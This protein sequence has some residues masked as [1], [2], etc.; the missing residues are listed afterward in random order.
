MNVR[1]L[2]LVFTA[3][4]VSELCWSGLTPLVPD[5]IEL[6]DLT[7]F[8]GGLIFAVAGVG[9]LV[10]SL[11]A[12]YITQRISP[13]ILTLWALAVVILTCYA[14][15]F[16]PGYWSLV[17]TRA[18]F[19]VA[20]GTLWVSIVA[21]LDQAAG[22]QSPRVL[23][24]TTTTVAVAATLSPAYAGW[25]AQQFSLGA[26]FVGL[27]VVMSFV[28]LM[29]LFERSGT[30]LRKDPAPPARALVRSMGSDPGLATMLLLT[31]AAAMMWMTSD[32][33][34]PLRLDDAGY[35]A[36]GIGLAFS[37]AACVFAIAS[38]VAARQANHWTRPRFAAFWTL[39]TAAAT[40]IPTVFAGVPA[41]LAFL[42]AASIATG[43]TI[44]LTFPFGLL[45]VNRGVVS[46]AVMSAMANIIWAVSGIAGPT[47]GGAFAEWAGDQVAFGVLAMV[48]VVVAALVIW[49]NRREPESQPDLIGEADIS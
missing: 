15:P 48:S 29:L 17:L 45:A 24:L 19:G 1:V 5:Y 22:D 21:W 33:L 11:P 32:L 10:A 31:I 43:I 44:S 37:L 27:A 34:V 2:V 20:F 39:A 18:L 28:L 4:F 13:R 6:Y 35:D 36:R 8:E 42:V 9:I 46:V 3:L 12:S 41:T 25:V 40:V 16:L 49:V 38:G 47:V 7:D 30:G 14:M 23:A 26:P